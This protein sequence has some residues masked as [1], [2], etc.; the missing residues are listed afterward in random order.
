MGEEEDPSQYIL[1]NME[2]WITHPPWFIKRG[3]DL[4]GLYAG[5]NLIE[6][7]EE[8]WTGRQVACL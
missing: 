1:L 5:V 3:L 2:P 7:Q 4:D 6:V 8:H